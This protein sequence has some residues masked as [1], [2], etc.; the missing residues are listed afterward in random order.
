MTTPGL[1]ANRVNVTVFVILDDPVF[2]ILISNMKSVILTSSYMFPAK[3]GL[4]DLFQKKCFFWVA[5]T[6][7]STLSQ[8]PPDTYPIEAPDINR[9]LDFV[10]KM[11]N[12]FSGTMDI[13]FR[14]E[15]DRGKK[16]GLSTR[17]RLEYVGNL[18]LFS[19]GVRSHVNV[20]E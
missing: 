19:H 3:R 6:S 20:A 13:A 18:S 7:N 10:C 1:V 2:A 17:N 12:Q 9:C 14:I 8:F 4:I 15:E 11:N 16:S 5:N